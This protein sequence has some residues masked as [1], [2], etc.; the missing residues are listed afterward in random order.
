MRIRPHL[1]WIAAVSA[2]VLLLN[3]RPANALDMQITKDPA[4]PHYIL[5]LTQEQREDLRTSPEKLAEEV[6]DAILHTM[7]KQGR[8]TG[9]SW[10]EL[11]IPVDTRSREDELQI[12]DWHI[13]LVRSAHH[14]FDRLGVYPKVRLTINRLFSSPD[15]VFEHLSAAD[16]SALRQSEAGL[17]KWI[18]RE[19]DA[20]ATLS[21]D[22]AVNGLVHRAIAAEGELRE[23]LADAIGTWPGNEVTS[24][25]DLKWMW[26]TDIYGKSI[27]I[28]KN[29]A[30]A[31]RVF[32][33]DA[34]RKRLDNNE[35][36]DAR[37]LADKLITA[38]NTS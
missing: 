24:Q 37:G 34:V 6:R 1:A 4:P 9:S 20:N 33:Y 31:R 5:F 38:V 27:G 17:E 2:A 28:G 11:R 14:D 19:M 23:S 35:L 22:E 15:P 10:I 7:E 21:K 26:I 32:P 18:S 3:G 12:S 29:D 25:T 36:F 13:D 30:K 8:E 16:E